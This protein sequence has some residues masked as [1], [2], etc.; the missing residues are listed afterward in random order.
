MGEVNLNKENDEIELTLYISLGN[1]FERGFL[2]IIERAVYDFGYR[3]LNSAI[4]FGTISTLI[5]IKHSEWLSGNGENSH[6]VNLE[7]FTKI[8]LRVLN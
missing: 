2:R 4:Q 3:T 6:D 5:E 8:L 1:M 7:S